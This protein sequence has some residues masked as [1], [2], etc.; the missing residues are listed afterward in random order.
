VKRFNILWFMVGVLTVLLCVLLYLLFRVVMP[1]TSVATPTPVMTV[2]S[3]PTQLETPIVPTATSIVTPGITASPEPEASPTQLETPIVSSPTPTQS[4]TPIPPAS[5]TP[6]PVPASPTPTLTPVPPTATSATITDWKGE[7][8]DNISL[9]PPPKVV[10]NDLVVDFSLPKGTAP[11][12]NMPSEN[13]SARWTRN[14]NFSEG[15]YRFHLVVDDGA[16]LWVAGHFLIDAWVDG[17]PREYVGDLYLKGD[18]PIKL[19]YYN[20]LGDAR[21]RLNWEQVTK[22]AGWQGSY[23]AVRDLSG[24]PLFQRD[25]ET[26]DFNWGIGSPRPDLPVDNFSVRWTRRLQVA[27]AGV[28]R[29]RA[30]SDDGV[31]VWVGGTS[32]IDQWHDGSSTYE[33]QIQLA[34]GDTDV[35]VE[36][37]EHTGGAAIKVIWELLSGP[38]AT[39][40]QTSTTLP[41]T[42]TRTPIPVTSTVIPPPVTPIPPTVTPIPPTLTPIPPTV[43][44]I[45]PTP[46]STPL[47]VTIVPSVTPPLPGPPGISLDPAA[48][49]ISKPFT[50]L[51][52]GW[53]AKTTVE[54]YLAQSGSQTGRSATVGQ[55]VTD[56][57][58]NF[59]ASFMVPAGEGWEGKESA[60]VMAV[61]SD[62]RYTA[63]AVYKLLPELKKV[64]FSP[65]PATEDRFALAEQ[66]YLVLSSADEWA[67]RFG[68]EPPP[69]QPP[70]DWQ[71]E[72][73]I[74][75]FLGTQSGDAQVSNIVQRGATVSTWLSIPVSENT[76]PGQSSSDTKRVLVR[77]SREAL[78][79]DPA[80]TASASPTFAFLDAMGRLL[81]QG[82]AGTVPP[83]GA[84]P[85]AVAPVEQQ[86]AAPAP[87]ATQEA[88][89]AEVT[90]VVEPPIEVLAAAEPSATVEPAAKAE[91]SMTAEPTKSETSTGNVVA[92]VLLAVGVVALIGVGLYLARR[93][94]G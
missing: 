48:G 14:W 43:T 58:G 4:P 32:V 46:T 36:Y 72:I 61:A 75:A 20:H 30:T 19:E 13:W 65:I 91:P 25:D 69:V 24:L 68:P 70:V 45:P 22:F 82:P 2:T 51:G 76:Q 5:A 44:L 1:A 88:A 77:V 11:A 39:P 47:P 79:T 52:R 37:Y 23:Y 6:T 53:P 34:A 50:V 33:G 54:L 49:P 59:S 90:Q 18:T 85:K 12:S 57:Q 67:A 73:V 80:I 15:S 29:F 81:A 92:G 87:G 42:A 94:G 7:Y 28:Y 66:T 71:R 38:T 21:V 3:E 83:V 41:P 26:I 64:A 78:Q 56:E 74:G 55:V 17:G 86:L 89:V 84:Q 27:Q 16:R 62:A 93:R 8:F 63:G 35:R 9:Q 31:R 60:R 10:R 40:T